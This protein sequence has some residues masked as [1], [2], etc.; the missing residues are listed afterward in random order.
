VLNIPDPEYAT[1]GETEVEITDLDSGKIPGRYTRRNRLP[2]FRARAW[3]SI[4]MIGGR[5]L[6][7]VVV[8]VSVSHLPKVARVRS[9]VPINYPVS[10]SV[11]DGIC[12]AT[13]TNGV[14]TAL[15]DYLHF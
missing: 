8:L 9:P 11:V 2:S 3:M 4:G 14:V 1:A 12:Y 7:V 6:L 10:L 13:A 5:A 15:R